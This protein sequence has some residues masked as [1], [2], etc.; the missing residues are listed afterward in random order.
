MFTC[1]SFCVLLFYFKKHFSIT[2][3]PI[4]SNHEPGIL[5][6][7]HISPNPFSSPSTMGWKWRIPM[8]EQSEG[9]KM[10]LVSKILLM[11]RILIA[12]A[13]EPWGGKQTSTQV[14]EFFWRGRGDLCFKIHLTTFSAN[15]GP[16]YFLSRFQHNYK[17][18]IYWTRSTLRDLRRKTLS[19]KSCLFSTGRPLRTPPSTWRS[20][21]KDWLDRTCCKAG[22]VRWNVNGKYNPNRLRVT[23][24]L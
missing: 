11:D 9:K 20:A 6:F 13:G 16:T 12:Q 15:F 8:E 17:I 19:T 4:E 7:L 14:E 3:Q 5:R 23:L 21:S 1:S 24:I 18:S 22:W 10:I 2:F